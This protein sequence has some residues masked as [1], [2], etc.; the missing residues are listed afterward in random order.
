MLK[1][2]WIDGRPQWNLLSIGRTK[3]VQPYY[4]LAII[5]MQ[6]MPTT[7]WTGRTYAVDAA[8]GARSDDI[9]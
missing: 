3:S 2:T 4:R 6:M 7:S 1:A 8:A 9:S 5:T